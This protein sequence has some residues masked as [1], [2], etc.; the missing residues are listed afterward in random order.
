MEAEAYQYLG[1]ITISV[2]AVVKKTEATIICPWRPMKVG[3]PVV[4]PMNN[5]QSAVE[6]NVNTVLISIA[7][8]PMVSPSNRPTH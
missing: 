5:V 8:Y 6:W 4:T 7:R 1:R 3:K 2:W